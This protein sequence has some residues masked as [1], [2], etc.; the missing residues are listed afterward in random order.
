M[1]KTPPKNDS[2]FTRWYVQLGILFAVLFLYVITKNIFF[3]MFLGVLI[4]A[5]VALEVKQHQHTKQ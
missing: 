3:G 4:V 1:E 2:L 5:L